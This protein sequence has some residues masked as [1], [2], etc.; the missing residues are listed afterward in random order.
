MRELEAVIERSLLLASGDMIVPE[1]LP[2][3]V[4]AG[5][6][7]RRAARS[8]SRSR[9]PGIDLEG[10]ERSLILKALEKTDGQRLAGRAP[11]RPVPPHPPVPPGEDPR[12]PEWGIG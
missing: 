7:R 1:D 10:V 8:A 12:C 5:I 2:A 6:T 9:S 3:A 4:R 11:A